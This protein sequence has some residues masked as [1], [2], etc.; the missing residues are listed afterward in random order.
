M[1]IMLPSPQAQLLATL[2]TTL[3]G[4]P[5]ADHKITTENMQQLLA[6]LIDELGAQTGIASEPAWL[7]WQYSVDST[8][9][10]S[11]QIDA[12][13]VGT[14]VLASQTNCASVR[15]TVNGRT[16]SLPFTVVA[17]EEVMVAVTR[18]HPGAAT[19]QLLR[20]GTYRQLAAHIYSVG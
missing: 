11:Y 15:V 3:A 20:V 9:W 13:A 12:A 18:V 17:G 16:V 1:P 19:V 2:A 6:T 5:P 14:Y 4:T 8:D 7:D 10:H